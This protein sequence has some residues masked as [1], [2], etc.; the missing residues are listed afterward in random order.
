M[1]KL[2]CLEA[3]SHRCF[4]FGRGVASACLSILL[5]PQRLFLDLLS[6]GLTKKDDE[7]SRLLE[8]ASFELDLDMMHS[9]NRQI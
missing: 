5:E 4:G 6:G 1:M 2:F 8:T 7:L 9:H 3:A